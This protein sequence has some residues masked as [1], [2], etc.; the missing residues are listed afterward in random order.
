M[1][2]FPGTAFA[3]LAVGLLAGC[4]T[5]STGQP[6]A[7]VKDSLGVRL[8]DA[9]WDH[10][11]GFE[12][13][14]EPDLILGGTDDPVLTFYGVRDITLIGDDLLAIIDG[15]AEQIVLVDI[16]TGY[17]RR[18]GAR[19]DG[20]TEFRGLARELAGTAGGTHL[21]FVHSGF[22]PD[23]L[24]SAAQHEAGWLGGLAELRRM[25]ELGADWT[26]VSTDLPD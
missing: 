23:E 8:V 5:P 15:S 18:I 20:P 26:P 11:S 7:T 6:A 9:N 19:G 21:T 12:V 25:H 13:A 14:A 22:G 16:S 3:L 10:A 4:G 2:R 24:D 1:D 17:V